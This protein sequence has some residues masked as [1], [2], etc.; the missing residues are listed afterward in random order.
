MVSYAHDGGCALQ[1][2]I[3]ENSDDHGAL[4]QNQSSGAFQDQVAEAAVVSWAA[5]HVDQ[6]ALELH[7]VLSLHQDAAAQK[8]TKKRFG[9]DCG[10]GQ[11]LRAPNLSPFCGVC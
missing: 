3:L 6:S 1:S 5:V 8:F 7:P 11:I 9:V 4:N 2:S 10:R